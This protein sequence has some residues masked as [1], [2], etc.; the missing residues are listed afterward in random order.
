MKAVIFDLD[1]TLL[2]TIGTIA[3]YGNKALSAFGF[4]TAT[5]EEYKYFVGNG[6][7]K[8][9]ERALD[10]SGEWT[11]EDFSK[12]YNYYNEIYNSKPLYLTGTFPGIGEMLKTLKGSGIKLGVLSNKPDEAVKGVVE[13]F[14]GGIFDAVS[15]GKEG[16]PLKPDPSAVNLMLSSLGAEKARSAFIGDSGV[17]IMTGKNAALHTIGVNWGFRTEDELKKAG[18]EHIVSSPGEIIK[19]IGAF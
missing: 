10:K 13:S 11:G 2:N 1:G 4:Q 5:E 8:L 7:V 17:D 15:G 16:V 19:L 18:A 14:F 12:V 6:A 9:I 3:Y